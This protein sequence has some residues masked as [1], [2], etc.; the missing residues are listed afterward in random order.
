MKPIRIDAPTVRPLNPQEKRVYQL[1]KEGVE[2]FEISKRLHIWFKPDT[3]LSNNHDVGAV[4]IQSIICSIREK[5]WTLPNE[6]EEPMARISK[7]S[8]EDKRNIVTAYQD[9]KNVKDIAAD[10]GLDKSYAYKI[11]KGW[12]E[13]GENSFTETEETEKEPATVG[14]VTSSEDEMDEENISAPIIAETTEDVKSDIE[15]VE[16]REPTI[17]KVIPDSVLEACRER[18]AVLRKDVEMWQASI[19]IWNNEI[20]EMQEFI[21]LARLTNPMGGNA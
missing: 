4:T 16:V 10:L 19:D 2:P 11:I 1:L 8:V 7:L 9:G 18:I 12:K 20:A 3:W 13:H 15:P 5:G 21:E 14:A 17:E 6:E